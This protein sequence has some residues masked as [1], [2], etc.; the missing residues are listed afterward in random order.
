[1]STQPLGANPVVKELPPELLS[2][3]VHDHLLQDPLDTSQLQD[4][5]CFYTRSD[6]QTF[7]LVCRAWNQSLVCDPRFWCRLHIGGP[8]SLDLADLALKRA[9][10]ADFPLV[11]SLRTIDYA[12]QWQ[13]DAVTLIFKLLPR[14]SELSLRLLPSY[15]LPILQHLVSSGAP[16]LRK[17]LLEALNSKEDIATSLVFW[18]EPQ[19]SSELAPAEALPCLVS[20]TIIS[21]RPSILSDPFP[22]PLENLQELVIHNSFNREWPAIGPID[23]LLAKATNTKRLTVNTGVFHC[24]PLL[25]MPSVL[26]ASLTT[27]VFH[28]PV[29]NIPP[30]Y[31]TKITHLA[32][33]GSIAD[34]HMCD[35]FLE[36]INALPE[37][38]SLALDLIDSFV[39]EPMPVLRRGKRLN[40]LQKLLLRTAPHFALHLLATFSLP[41]L[42]DLCFDDAPIRVD[43]PEAWTLYELDKLGRRMDDLLLLRSL[44]VFSRL[45]SECVVIIL[46]KTPNLVTLH[47]GGLTMAQGVFEALT[48]RTGFN[49]GILCPSLRSVAIV[50]LSTPMTLVGTRRNWAEEGLCPEVTFVDACYGK[51]GLLGL[52]LG[53]DGR[54]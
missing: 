36:F 50:G 11:L 20:L 46:K 12:A 13:R 17:I 47:H 29:I 22:I 7:R 21:L 45:P 28:L 51:F 43:A 42:T 5:G 31:D 33:T 49:G 25:N 38:R 18:D 4:G 53:S 27:R 32:L 3:V 48:S 35:R 26:H 24:Q 44:G 1:M 16:L 54:N 41:R 23:A 30:N 9:E 6:F 52:S 8:F 15:L 10:S 2:L 40:H 19:P 37:L 39:V 14:C 34:F